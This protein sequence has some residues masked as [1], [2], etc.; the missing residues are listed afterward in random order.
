[1]PVYQEYVGNSTERGGLNL[2]LH[3]PFNVFN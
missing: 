1:M 3:C 2:A